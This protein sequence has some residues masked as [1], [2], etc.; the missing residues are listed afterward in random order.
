[1]ENSNLLRAEIMRMGMTHAEVA[2]RLGMSKKTF[3][4]RLNHG[5]FGLDEAQLMREILQM[6]DKTA[7]KIFLPKK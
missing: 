6:D 7:Y 4:L 2:K 3:S 1:M 5:S